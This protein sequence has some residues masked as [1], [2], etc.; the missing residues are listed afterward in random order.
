M[1]SARGEISGQ[2]PISQFANEST[3]ESRRK[4]AYQTK[5]SRRERKTSSRRWVTG[6][7]WSLVDRPFINLRSNPLVSV[8][9]WRIKNRFNVTFHSSLA[10]HL[11]LIL[12]PGVQ[13]PSHPSPASPRHAY[14]YIHTGDIVGR[15]WIDPVVK[16]STPHCRDDASTWHD[17][18]L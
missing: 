3:G 2:V 14:L 13:L 6:L 10:I 9:C 1:R 11:S 7:L 16:P 12:R 17:C 5:H 8:A 4:E 18:F 15:I